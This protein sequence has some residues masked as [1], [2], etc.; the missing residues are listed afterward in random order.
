MI[1][2]VWFGKPK[3][4]KEVFPYWAY[5]NEHTFTWAGVRF[6]KPQGKPVYQ[7]AIDY[8]T[9]T[10][11]RWMMFGP[12]DSVAEAK[13]AAQKFDQETITGYHVINEHCWE[14]ICERISEQP[15]PSNAWTDG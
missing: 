2:Q 15:Y 8:V 11:V 6:W 12:F 7:W 14:S 13:E 4:P 9:C 10:D 1:L 3:P 5:A